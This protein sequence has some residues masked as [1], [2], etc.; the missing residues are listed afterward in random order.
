[1]VI[2]GLPCESLERVDAT[3]TNVEDLAS[4]L[5]DCT[6]ESLSDLALAVQRERPGC[7]IGTSHGLMRTTTT[8]M[9]HSTP[10]KHNKPPGNLL[11]ARVPVVVSAFPLAT[12][13]NDAT[14]G[15]PRSCANQHP[16]AR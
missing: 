11:A 6:C 9:A 4:D 3:D 1:M 8:E 14:L 16:P 7:V 12:P 2:P 15:T 13:A 5:I 10:G